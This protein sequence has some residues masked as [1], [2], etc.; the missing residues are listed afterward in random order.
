MKVRITEQPT[1]LL[2]GKEWPT[3]GEVIDLPDVV[4]VDLLNARMAEPVK[5]AAPEAAT[6]PAGAVETAVKKTAPRKKG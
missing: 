1:G 5:A 4:A 3:A 6:A 2:N